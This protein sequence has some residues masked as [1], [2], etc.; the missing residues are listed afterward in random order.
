MKISVTLEDVQK[1][2]RYSASHCPIALAGRR[3]FSC[4]GVFVGVTRLDLYREDKH[5]RWYL[6]PEVEHFINEFDAQHPVEPFEFELGEPF[7]EDL[8]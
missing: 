4:L 8:V 1:G 5:L 7:P 6:S 2:E 3:A